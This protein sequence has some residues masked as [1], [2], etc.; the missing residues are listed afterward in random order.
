MNKIHKIHS[1]NP[2]LTSNSV[3]PKPAFY[4]EK[5]SLQGVESGGLLVVVANTGLYDRVFKGYID[6]NTY[7]YRPFFDCNTDL[8][9]VV[10]DGMW[11]GYPQDVLGTILTGIC[12][13]LPN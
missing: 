7:G 12:T 8:V 9:P 6:P 11:Q 3:T 1:W 10:L 13:F 2:T 5:D 4:I